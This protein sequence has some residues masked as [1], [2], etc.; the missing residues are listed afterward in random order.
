M[1]QSPTTNQYE[2]VESK[3]LPE[4][5]LVDGTG[6]AKFVAAFCPAFEHP[7]DHRAEHASTPAPTAIN[8]GPCQL[9]SPVGPAGI[10]RLVSPGR[11]V[12]RRHRRQTGNGEVD[13]EGEAQLFALKPLG[14]HGRD[15]NDHGFGA[16]TQHGAAGDHHSR[17]SARGGERGS[18]QA[19]C[20]QRT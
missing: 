2:G 15:R 17:P 1:K 14:K 18:Q 20:R 6:L 3:D 8:N 7:V 19:K 9:G 16:Q 4:L 11:R 10:K 5:Q 12:V 13:P